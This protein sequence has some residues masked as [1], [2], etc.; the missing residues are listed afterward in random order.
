VERDDG[1]AKLIHESKASYVKAL[2]ATLD[3]HPCNTPIKS[4]TNK[5]TFSYNMPG[6]NIKI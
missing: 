6:T 2:K 1:L 5:S 4:S 3:F